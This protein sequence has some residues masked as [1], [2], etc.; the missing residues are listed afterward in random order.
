MPTAI[1]VLTHQSPVAEGLR[2]LM[3]PPAWLGLLI[4]ALLGI[5]VAWSLAPRAEA[6]DMV[7]K[8]RELAL[9]GIVMFLCIEPRW[10]DRVL[11]APIS[12]R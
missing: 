9:F 10:R 3:E 12:A 4:L 6:L 5:G 1:G 11:T 2:R 8:Y 7:V